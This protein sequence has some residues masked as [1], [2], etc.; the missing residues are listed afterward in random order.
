MRTSKRIN[1]NIILLAVLIALAVCTFSACDFIGG[2]IN[3]TPENKVTSVRIEYDGLSKEDGVLYAEAGKTFTL[4]AVINDDA[5]ANP[6]YKWYVAINEGTRKLVNGETE[7]TLSVTYDVHD[8]KVRTYT[9]EVDGVQSSNSIVVTMR[10]SVG[11]S[12]AT[13]SSDPPSVSGIVQQKLGKTSPVTLTA[14]WNDSALAPDVTVTIS[15][16]VG[17]NTEPASTE[18]SFT[19]TPTDEEG[20]TIILLV[21]S[22]GDNTTKATI[23]IS[24]VAYYDAVDEVSLS[25]VSGAT[26]FGDLVQYRQ[27]ADIIS[28]VTVSANIYPLTANMSKPVVWT[29]EDKNG[30]RTLSETSSTI[31]F[32]PAYGETYVTATVD[33]I[34]SRHLVVIAMT[35]YDYN[36]HAEAI[37]YTYIWRDGVYN[38]YI[39]NDNDMGVFVAYIESHRQT[40]SSK[41]DEG[42]YLCMP[43]SNFDMIIPGEKGNTINVNFDVLD[44]S[45]SY[46]VGAY[47][48]SSDDNKYWIFFN[49]STVFNHP[50][51]DYSPAETVVQE[52]NVILNYAELPE[53]EKR[54]SIPADSFDTYP[55]KITN[56]DMLYRVLGWGYKP[57]FENDANGNK[58]KT[59]YE[60]ARKMLVNYISADMTDL[61]KVTVIYEWIAQTV[62]YDYA[63]VTAKAL[64]PDVDS[65]SYNA[66]SLEGV[67][68]DGDGD[69]FGQAV[70]DGRAKAFVLLCGMEGISALRI[71]GEANVMGSSEGHAW[72]KVLVDVDDSGVKEWYMLDTTWSDRSGS[73]PRKESLNHQYF[74]VTDDYVSSSHIADEDEYNPVADTEYSYYKNATITDGDDVI[75]LYISSSAELKKALD[76]S[77]KNGVYVELSFNPS[78]ISSDEA[79]RQQLKGRS[80]T[81]QSLEKGK[82]YLILIR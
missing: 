64:S 27:R 14:G 31:T 54:T 37:E 23:T 53:S 60:N 74:L 49:D 3:A 73:T 32:T 58:L 43:S 8:E 6:K 28:P 82:T 69:G 77:K 11:V 5:P 35:E 65:L 30:T 81:F 63:I 70:C 44:V 50:T 40:A 1:I 76:Y 72:N 24:V 41:D 39:L 46:S 71:C 61:E 2:I 18:K 17:D 26:A 66:Y 68:L 10:Y 36:K 59:I 75:S 55:E 9:V 56:S 47:Y 67:F 20:N 7:K 16:F 51:E 78:F 80:Y 15:W 57:S 4:T 21:L 62:N 38:S 12:N 34:V 33:N 13:I 22:D 19:Y 79:L 52:T 48:T 45:G 25:L 29:V 42:A